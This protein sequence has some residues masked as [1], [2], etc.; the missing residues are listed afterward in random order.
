MT[1]PPLPLWLSRSRARE[2]GT[3]SAEQSGG[4]SSPTPGNR[5][6]TRA[7]T[8]DPSLSFRPLC[9]PSRPLAVPP[10]QYIDPIVQATF[11]QDGQIREIV[12]CLSAKLRDP[13]QT[14]RGSRAPTALTASELIQ[15]FRMRPGQVEFKALIVLHTIMRSG[16]LEAV[17]SYL[18]TSS[19]SLSLSSPEAANVAAYG[20]YLAC[21]IKSYGNLKRDVVRDKSDRRAAN[22]LKTLTVE[23]GLLRETREIQRMIAALV[24]AKV[25]P[26]PRQS[27]CTHTDSST[28]LQ[29]YTE[30]VD[31]DVSMTAL[32]LLVKDLLV[33]FT[34]VN[35]GV[36]NVLEHYFEMSHVDATLALKIYKTFC[37]DTEKVVAYLGTAKRLYNVLNIPIPNIRHAPLSLAKSLEEYLNDP[38]FEQNRQEYK[39]NKRIADGGR[40]R[41]AW[42]C[43]LLGF[44]FFFET[45]LTPLC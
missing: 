29:F 1:P 13:S 24:E 36:I 37:R 26:S 32:R 27:P 39:E 7:S 45:D 21:R 10:S 22:R 31:D 12:Q 14:V 11:Q 6:L 20:Q 5:V 4:S 41:C 25:G 33:L 8:A 18:S 34:A 23:Q 15:T 44:S 19:T 17:F 43:P 16:H 3:Q 30:D 2:T 42:R 40:P 38:N 35:E 28:D 9:G